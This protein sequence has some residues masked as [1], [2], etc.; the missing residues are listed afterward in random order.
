MSICR[1]YIY[2]YILKT[3]ATGVVLI[4]WGAPQVAGH[5]LRSV[6]T[7]S[8]P[9]AHNAIL[10]LKTCRAIQVGPVPLEN[11]SI[12][13]KR[14]LIRFGPRATFTGWICNSM[15]SIKRVQ[16]VIRRMRMNRVLFSVCVCSS[17]NMS[18]IP[19][20]FLYWF[21]RFPCG[22]HLSPVLGVF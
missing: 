10:V 13:K 20:I 8:Q 17:V 21:V 1:V 3:M 9:K 15:H 18:T 22:G 16:N 6:K 4:K 11:I 19:W 7:W 14:T 2:L 12:N 5:H